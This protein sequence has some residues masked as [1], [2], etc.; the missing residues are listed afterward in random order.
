MAGDVG[1]EVAGALRLADRRAQPRDGQRVFG[2]AVDVPLGGV[3][4]KG[5]DG[6]PF[7]DAEGIALEDAPVHERPG[8]A[9]VGVADDVLL[10]AVSLRDRGPLQPGEVTRSSPTAKAAP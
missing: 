8:V 9:L 3:D 1:A 2:S 7:E 6:H 10:L 5:R 4:G